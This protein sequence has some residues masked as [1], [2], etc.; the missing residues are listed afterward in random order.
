MAA[1][2]MVKAVKPTIF[3]LGG[4]LVCSEEGK[5]ESGAPGGGGG[6]FFIENP[7][8]GGGACGG[9]EGPGGCLRGIWGG[10]GGS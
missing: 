2:K 3:L 4:F 1:M 9:R 8:R 5:G 7:R 6:R 10:G